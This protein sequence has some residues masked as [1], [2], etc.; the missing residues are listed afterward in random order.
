MTRGDV[1]SAKQAR[2]VSVNEIREI[3]MDLDGDGEKYY[4]SQE[5]EDKEEPLPLSRQSSI[6]QTFVLTET[7]FRTITQRP[8]Y[9][10]YFRPSS[11][12]TVET[13]TTI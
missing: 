7:V 8:T 5:L 3:V 11:L 6:S 1:S 9:K 10:T 4:P 12:Q 2:V 13:S